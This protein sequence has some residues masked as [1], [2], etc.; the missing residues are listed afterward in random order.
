MLNCS[1]QAMGRSGTEVF[2]DKALTEARVKFQANAVTG[3]S[4]SDKGDLCSV[5]WKL[6]VRPRY[7]SNPHY[8]IYYNCGQEYQLT[9]TGLKKLLKVTPLP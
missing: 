9:P 6:E 5:C 1:R 8:L 2:L 4:Q 3:G 7:S